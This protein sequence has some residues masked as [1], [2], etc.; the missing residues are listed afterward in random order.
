MKRI[1]IISLLAVFLTTNYAYAILTAE[2]LAQG[3]EKAKRGVLSAGRKKLLSVIQKI[4]SV[5]PASEKLPSRERKP[6]ERP[7]GIAV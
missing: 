6:S 2:D 5:F 4:F 7:E 1:A 3:M